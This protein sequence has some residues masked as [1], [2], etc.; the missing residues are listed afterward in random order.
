MPA[1]RKCEIKSDPKKSAPKHIKN[2]R[3]PHRHTGFKVLR[4][5]FETCFM[6][7]FGGFFAHKRSLPYAGWGGAVRGNQR[8]QSPQQKQTGPKMSRDSKSSPHHLSIYIR[9]HPPPPPAPNKGENEA[10]Q[11]TTSEAPEPRKAGRIVTDSYGKARRGA[12]AAALHFPLKLLVL[13][14]K[15]R[16]KKQKRP[17]TQMEN[18]GMDTRNV[19]HSVGGH[20][21]LL[22][23]SRVLQDRQKGSNSETDL[24]VVDAFKWTVA[25]AK[26]AKQNKHDRIAIR[27]ISVSRG[28]RRPVLRALAS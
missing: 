14:L 19:K 15:S 9:M 16:N 13:H 4:A 6:L 3:K 20:C 7:F 17:K 21:G 18:Q 8:T 2:R 24:A 22:V 1:G 27:F 28:I 10:A 25:L 23:G 11:H 5:G 12:L 26:M